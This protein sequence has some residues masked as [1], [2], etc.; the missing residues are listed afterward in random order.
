MKKFVSRVV[1]GVTALAGSA[2]AMA[3][4]SSAGVTAISELEGEAASLISAAW[5]VA[6]AIMAGMIGIKL[7]KKFAN[8]A[9]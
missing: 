1:V 8:R 9:S 5:P 7:F 2:A 4:E 6:T 3:T